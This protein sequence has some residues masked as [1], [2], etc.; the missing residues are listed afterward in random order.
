MKARNA[1]NVTELL[2]AARLIAN[3]A[4]AEGVSTVGAFRRARSDHLGAIL[5]DAVLQA[6][7][8]YATVV[9]PR[10][11]RIVREY[12][13][14]SD[15]KVLMTIV[16]DGS[17]SQFLNWKHPVKSS[18]FEHIVMRLHDHGISKAEC[19]REKLLEE[20]F[21]LSL[22]AISGIG[23]KTIDYMACLT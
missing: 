16:S 18:R 4:Y 7:L 23:P 13:E 20:P 2:T 12:P 5:A 11:E 17:V 8:N 22:K 1:G 9:R 21:R 6:G 3:L 10:V 14:A 15:M 19:L